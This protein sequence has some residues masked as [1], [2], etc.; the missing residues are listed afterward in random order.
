MELAA[1]IA[2]NATAEI[3][4]S[5]LNLLKLLIVSSPFIFLL[6]IIVTLNKTGKTMPFSQENE[7]IDLPSGLL[8]TELGKYWE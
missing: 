1:V 5:F 2:A 3:P 7:R 8:P 4:A 6:Q